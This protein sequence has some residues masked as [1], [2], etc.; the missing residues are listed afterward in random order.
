VPALQENAD[1][2]HVAPFDRVEREKA[3]LAEYNHGLQ[4]VRE[5]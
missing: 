5:F 2:L 3:A 1:A 4:P